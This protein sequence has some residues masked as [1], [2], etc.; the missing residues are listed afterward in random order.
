MKRKLTKNAFKIRV[1]LCIITG[2]ICSTD[3]RECAGA[4]ARIEELNEEK[5]KE[6]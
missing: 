4:K 6:K 3:C 5:E 2:E 1:Y